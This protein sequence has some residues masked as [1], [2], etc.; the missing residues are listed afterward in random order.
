M[1]NDPNKIPWSEKRLSD[2]EMAAKH[3][4]AVLEMEL[5]ENIRYYQNECKDHERRF[6]LQ[7]D[8]TMRAIKAWQKETGKELHWP[9][10]ADL[11][12][13]ML[14]KHDELEQKTERIMGW[15]EEALKHGLSDRVKEGLRLSK[16]QL[17]LFMK[18]FRLP[19]AEPE[20]EDD[21]E[22]S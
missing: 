9:D 17:K 5:M 15:I 11:I 20:E 16:D 14:K 19:I 6:D 10:K 22:R 13:W 21:Q 12:V 1:D 8:A 18:D 7:W 4:G 3:E 2:Q